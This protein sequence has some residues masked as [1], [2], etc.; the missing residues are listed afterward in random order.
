[1]EE[2]EDVTANP[3]F[4]ALKQQFPKMYQDAEKQGL[5]LLVPHSSVSSS[6][7]F[8]KQIFGKNA[9]DFLLSHFSCAI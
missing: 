5:T 7:K 1:M 4:R 3:F 6:M 2:E 9:R 8:S